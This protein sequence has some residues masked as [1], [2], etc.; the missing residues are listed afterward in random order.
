MSVSDS[1]VDNKRSNTMEVIST[2]KE[3]GIEVKCS[4]CASVLL[5]YPHEVR[6]LKL[7]GN[8]SYINCCVCGNF[9]CTD[10]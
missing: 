1:L 4:V 2:G 3:G 7:E 5:Y 6:K 8:K 9:I 10:D